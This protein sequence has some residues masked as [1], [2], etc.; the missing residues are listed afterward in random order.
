[1]MAKLF[2]ANWRTT[3]SGIGT[4]LFSSL[5]VL[6]ALPYD[7]GDIAN[8]FDPTWKRRIT[9]TAAVAAFALKWWNAVVQKDRTV[10][11]GALQQDAKGAIAKPQEPTPPPPEPALPEHS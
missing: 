8:I 11:G 1:M 3:I 5:T 7:M 2:G 6:A 9:I 10:T 4:A